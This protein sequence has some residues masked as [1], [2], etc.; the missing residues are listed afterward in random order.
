METHAK[1]ILSKRRTIGWITLGL[2]ACLIIAGIFDKRILGHADMMAFFHL[3]A[4]VFLVISAYQL[5]YRFRRDNQRALQKFRTQ[6]RS[7]PLPQ[8]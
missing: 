8:N 2:W 1:K 4:A 7:P 5:S 6:K 3:P